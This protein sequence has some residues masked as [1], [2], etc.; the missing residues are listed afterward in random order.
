MG[1]AASSGTTRSKNTS[2][3]STRISVLRT[4]DLLRQPIPLSLEARFDLFE[5][6]K[7]DLSDLASA[8][9]VMVS[10]S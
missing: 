4:S 5:A 1:P 2:S 7:S 10:M 3:R 8:V 9:T 6:F